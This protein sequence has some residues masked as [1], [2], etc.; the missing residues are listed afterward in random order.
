MITVHLI[1]KLNCKKEDKLMK[2]TKRKTNK[3]TKPN[4]MPI[5][6]HQEVNFVFN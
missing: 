3:I 2:L 6:N 5:K 1:L 4:M